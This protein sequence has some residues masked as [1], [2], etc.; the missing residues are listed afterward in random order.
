MMLL[1]VITWIL[2][3]ANA[4]TWIW[5]IFSIH[6]ISSCIVFLDSGLDYFLEILEKL[7]K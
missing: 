1:V 3:V 4:P 2:L 6:I 7:K 5:I